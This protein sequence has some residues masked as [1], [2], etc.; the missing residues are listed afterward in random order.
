[1]TAVPSQLKEAEYNIKVV[2]LINT[3][4]NKLEISLL[5]RA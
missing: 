1:M 4:D 2:D 5:T 3:F